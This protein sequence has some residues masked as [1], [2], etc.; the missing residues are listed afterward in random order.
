ME[1]PINTEPQTVDIDGLR[2]RNSLGLTLFVLVIF[3][4][5]IF[6][7]L[8]NSSKESITFILPVNAQLFIDE[9]EQ[10]HE[11]NI[12]FNN[13]SELKFISFS[14]EKGNH[15]VKITRPNHLPIFDEIEV[16]DPRDSMIYSLENEELVA[17]KK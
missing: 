14:L 9:I 10:S 7:V 8:M 3:F 11:L 1:P 6:F 13:Q 4:I 16:R 12:N 5:P 2:M 17:L 15:K